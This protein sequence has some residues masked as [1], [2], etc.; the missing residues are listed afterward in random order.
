MPRS[1]RQRANLE[2]VIGSI[3]R[4]CLGLVIVFSEG[5]LRILR[6]WSDWSNG[7]SCSGQAVAI[8]CT[9]T[10]SSDQRSMFYR[11]PTDQPGNCR[12]ILSS[13]GGLSCACLPL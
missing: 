10:P 13:L 1:Q 11:I 7:T 2:R 6:P 8:A 3:R 9:Q 5:S 4:D 12:C